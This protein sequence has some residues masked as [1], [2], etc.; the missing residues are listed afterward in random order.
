MFSPL[1]YLEA[2]SGSRHRE[3]FW[4]IVIPESFR[5]SRKSFDTVQHFFKN[6]CVQ[7]SL[8]LTLEDIIFKV[9]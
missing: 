1:T 3:D 8:L 6:N 9:Y 4:E 5:V 2:R 7:G